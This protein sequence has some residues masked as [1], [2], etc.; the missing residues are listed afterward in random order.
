MPTTLDAGDAALRLLCALAAASLIGLDRGEHGNSAGLR[1]NVLVCLASATSMLLANALIGTAG[2][3]PDS[4]VRLDMMRLPLG[5]LT[6]IGFIGAGAIVRRGALVQGVTTAATL[7][8]V[9][10]MGLCFGAGAFALGGAM[11]A[12]GLLVLQGFKALEKFLRARHFAHVKFVLRGDAIPCE[13]IRRGFADFSIARWTQ[14][15]EGD[16]TR[17]AF[18]V[19]WLARPGDLEPPACFRALRATRG[20]VQACW[21]QRQ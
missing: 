15:H 7:W 20:V 3:A 8:F 6:G 11:L 4:F 10:V 16:E 9:T 5:I 19:S 14:R 1:T 21:E 18:E 17:I 12:I 13:D 2:R